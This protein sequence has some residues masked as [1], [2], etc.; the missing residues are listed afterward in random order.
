MFAFKTS[1]LEKENENKLKNIN[2]NNQIKNCKL[3][4]QVIIKS[5]SG[6]PMRRD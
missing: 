2:I 5:L 1:L 4:H 3:P 6:G